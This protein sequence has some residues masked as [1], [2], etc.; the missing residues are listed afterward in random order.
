MATPDSIRGNVAIAGI[1]HTEFARHIDRTSL[2]L[3]AEAIQKA[4]DDC[5]LEKMEIDGLCTNFGAPMSV[6][7]DTVGEVLG[8]TVR[9]Y[10]QTWSHGRYNGSALQWATFAVHHGLANYVAIVFAHSSDRGRRNPRPEERETGTGSY[11]GSPPYGM[12]S[13]GAGAALAT[14]MYSHRYGTTDEDLAA[15]AISFRDNATLN[16]AAIM[17]EPLTLDEYMQAR[18]ICEPLR[19]WDY[20]LVNDGAACL[21]LTTAA[22]ARSL[23]KAPVYVLGLEGIHGGRQEFV[24]GQPGL[25]VQ[26]QDILAYRPDPKNQRSFQMADVQPKDINA[27]YTYDAFSY[28]VWVALERHGFC[29]PG[30]A[31]GFTQGGRI[32]LRGKLPMNTSGGLLSE[33]HLE[34]WG[35]H[36]EIVRQLRGECGARQVNGIELAM[37]GSPFGDAVIYGKNT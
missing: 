30:E 7:L 8:L 22:R 6:D 27:L 13:P 16:P 36:M 34:G 5:G 19:R 28:N 33:A 35:N 12:T 24:F 23:K 14:R 9:W 4:L 10:G 25:G 17:R 15:V 1:G 29:K 20:C 11:A 21:I 32:G 3:I 2:D 26:Q 37:Y 18:Y 31:A